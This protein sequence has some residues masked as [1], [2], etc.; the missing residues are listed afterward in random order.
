MIRNRRVELGKEDNED[1][2]SENE[3]NAAGEIEGAPSTVQPT[4][5]EAPSDGA[6]VAPLQTILP[7]SQ[8]I[9]TDAQDAS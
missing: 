6:S 1:A 8:I 9:P 5:L 4:I 2:P 3:F 7:S